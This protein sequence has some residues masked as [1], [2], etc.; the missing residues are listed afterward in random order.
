MILNKNFRDPYQANSQKEKPMTDSQFKRSDLV[1]LKGTRSGSM[2]ILELDGSGNA[3]CQIEKGGMLTSET[4]PT[5]LLV[6]LKPYSGGAFV[7]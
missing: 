6:K 4:F 7:V 5:D 1:R 2:L 3:V